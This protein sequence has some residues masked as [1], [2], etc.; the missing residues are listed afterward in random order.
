[1]ILPT[2]WTVSFIVFQPLSASHTADQLDKQVDMLVNKRVD[3]GVD[4]MLHFPLLRGQCPHPLHRLP[5]SLRMSFR[6]APTRIRYLIFNTEDTLWTGRHLIAGNIESIY[7]PTPTILCLDSIWNA[8]F[9]KRREAW[10]KTHIS[11]FRFVPFQHCQFEIMS[12]CCIRGWTK[13]H[14]FKESGLSIQN[15]RQIH[16]LYQHSTVLKEATPHHNK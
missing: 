5:S 11:E 4:H 14:V 7:I 16:Q 6:R 8:T 2:H 12:S 15:N 10:A 1:M 3:R 13:T 9:W